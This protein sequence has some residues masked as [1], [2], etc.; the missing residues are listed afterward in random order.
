[1]YLRDGTDVL[2]HSTAQ[3]AYIENGTYTMITPKGNFT[4]ALFSVNR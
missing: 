3:T 2:F 4:F 1:V